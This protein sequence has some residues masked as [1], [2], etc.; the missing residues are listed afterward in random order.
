MSESVVKPDWATRMKQAF[1][2]PKMSD[3]MQLKALELQ[4]ALSRD[5]LGTSTQEEFEERRAGE[6]L[7]GKDPGK[8]G[9]LEGATQENQKADNTATGENRPLSHAVSGHGKGSDQISR[10]V[11]GRR[12]DE[13]DADNA[14]PAQSIALTGNPNGIGDATTP[15]YTTVGK[16]PSN[17][18]GAFTSDKAMLGVVS[19]AFA[20]AN[21]I[22]RNAEATRESGDDSTLDQE[23]FATDIRMEGSDLGYNLEV[24]G[25]TE[26]R[27]DTPLAKDEAQERFKKLKKTDNIDGAKVVLDPAFTTVERQKIDKDGKKVFDV[28]GMPVMETVRQRVGWNL[29]T[30]FPTENAPDAGYAK[31]EDVTGGVHDTE[32][33]RRAAD[34][35]AKQAREKSSQADKALKEHDNQIGAKNRLIAELSQP[36]NPPIPEGEGVESL[37]LKLT[38]AQAALQKLDDE[39]DSL[40]PPKDMF[41]SE[42][43]PAPEPDGEDKEKSDELLKQRPTL[44]QAVEKYKAWVKSKEGE[45]DK[46]K[47]IEKTTS[48]RDELVRN[49]A[50]LAAQATKASEELEQAEEALTKA[51]TAADTAAETLSGGEGGG[52]GSQKVTAGYDP[53][54]GLYTGDRPEKPASMKGKDEEGDSLTAHHLYPWNKILKDLNDALGSKSASAMKKLFAFGKVVPDP[55]FWEELQKAPGERNYAFSETINHAAQ[56]ICWSEDN[57]F[58]GPLGSKRGDDPGEEV[59][60]AFTQSGLP[61]PASAMAELVEKRGGIGA[62][63]PAVDP[64]A[65]KPVGKRDPN[66]RLAELFEKNVL[67]AQGEGGSARP[68]DE[69][70]WETDDKGKKIRKGQVP[71]ADP[72]V[73]RAVS[74]LDALIGEMEGETAAAAEELDAAQKQPTRPVSVL[75]DA[76]DQLADSLRRANA[77]KIDPDVALRHP[78][79]GEK[80]AAELTK[81]R[82]DMQDQLTAIEKHLENI[83]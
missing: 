53:V 9:G 3:S 64:K 16:D 26:Q 15:N 79:I 49:R 30:A 72:V 75:E 74:A 10:A 77:H 67:E 6:I 83:G 23:R 40:V 73:K 24:E 47:L 25:A 29:Q 54:K 19:E 5:R 12:G 63:R 8:I 48:E 20:Q 69:N 76:R 71:E 37:R 51:E 55:S 18:T 39:V 45:A 32:S 41:A 82:K 33:K 57:V 52:G 81:L 42:D 38:E 22:S 78:E 4:A 34:A 31:P 44:E 11:H 46:L 80:L 21:M 50:P 58:M 65:P 17:T 56:A 14:K 59:D 28:G 70:E 43:D 13:M 7:R 35:V 2:P 60:A 27:K 62:E 1:K 68:Y 61:T 36:L 66:S